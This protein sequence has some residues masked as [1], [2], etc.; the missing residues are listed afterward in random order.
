M[1]SD[2]RCALARRRSGLSVAQAAKRLGW[3]IERLDMVE[4]TAADEV[5]PSDAE[6]LAELYGVTVEWMLGRAPRFDFERVDA[7]PGVENLYPRDR[8]AIAELLASLRPMP[9]EHLCSCGAKYISK[10]SLLD[11]C[12]V[13]EGIGDHRPA[14]RP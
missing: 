7:I 6:K 12:E 3:P 14:R 5:Y 8:E 10:Q 9:A 13:L 11:H 4:C 1:P 2:N